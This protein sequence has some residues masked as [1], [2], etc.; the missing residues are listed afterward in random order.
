[1]IFVSG[2]LFIESEDNPWL[3]SAVTVEQAEQPAQDSMN[4]RECE[5]DLVMLYME[6]QM[7]KAERWRC[8]VEI[9][10]ELDE[11]D[12]EGLGKLY[13]LSRFWDSAVYTASYESA[14]EWIE[15]VKFTK[16][17]H[18]IVEIVKETKSPEKLADFHL[19]LFKIFAYHDLL[20]DWNK[21]DMTG[22]EA[23]LRRELEE[24]RILL[25]YRFGRL[26]Y[27]RF[28]DRY[29]GTRTEHLAADDVASLLSGTPKGVYQMDFF[30]TGPFGLLKGKEHRFLP[31][32]R[33]LPL[34][35]CSDTGCRSIHT[36][37]LLPPDIVL[38]NVAHQINDILRDKLGPCSEWDHALTN[39]YLKRLDSETK[40]LE[41]A[42]LPILIAD[43]II[44]D[45]RSELVE[46]VL[47]C[48][49]RSYINDVLDSA[50]GE[51]LKQESPKE[52]ARKLSAEEQLQL[53]LI[54]KDELIIRLID[55]STAKGLVKV[56]LGQIRVAKQEVSLSS[57]SSNCELSRLGLRSIKEHPITTLALLTYKAYSENDSI[58]EMN[59]RLHIPSGVGPMDG[60][61]HY[62]QQNGPEVVVT[63]LVLS[64][65]SVTEYV[66]KKLQLPIEN[67]ESSRLKP[68]E[69]IL[70][71]IGFDPPAYDDFR[72]RFLDH[73]QKFNAVVLSSPTPQSEDDRE[74]VRAVGVN[75][76]VY[77]EK[78]LDMLISYNIWLLASDHF[79]V[80]EFELE[81]MQ[82]RE[83][84]AE[85]LGKSLESNGTSL[86]WNIQG[87]NSLGVLLRYMSESI[88]WIESLETQNRDIWK[89]PDQD[90]PHFV[91]V[92]SL[93]FPFNHILLW[94][95]SDLNEFKKY[96]VGYRKIAKL[97]QQAELSY[98][99][100]GL[101]HMRDEVRFPK[102]EKMLACV[103]RLREAYDLAISERYLPVIFWLDK[104]EG[105]RF[106][107]VDYHLRDSANQLLVV[108]GPPMAL[109]LNKPKFSKP[110]VVAPGNLIGGPNVNLIFGLQERTEYDEYW[111]DYPRRRQIAVSRV[112]MSKD[113][114]S[115][116][117]SS[118]CTREESPLVDNHH[119]E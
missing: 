21:S 78:M 27:D 86:E 49:E 97:L 59:W 60:L 45:E 69:V 51:S 4:F 16:A 50:L 35:H 102:S 91:E 57:L 119:T 110:H 15:L 105:S 24:S 58:N 39:R 117:P 38:T 84:V 87:E 107:V 99:R 5:T 74:K 81:L 76:F 46:E 47:K 118:S 96:L 92:M 62:I 30:L 10:V 63:D 53:L 77:V 75:L 103:S 54:L 116:A 70:W 85:V 18:E 65:K 20:I 61:L 89:R 14:P 95:D 26:L 88:S 106:G 72:N 115:R 22:I 37:E 41:Y 3:L 93:R 71:K 42:D 114:G 79:L 2:Q 83:R 67:I 98:V 82:A 101:D 66:C 90:L 111:K 17:G 6:A 48:K 68:V 9:D 100:N 7:D 11:I 73:L 23:L 55:E 25:P 32:S 8:V 13:A 31:P 19:A 80:T 1:M 33:H 40:S 36:V 28:N 29:E 12:D 108:H 113:G 44:G 104:I 112:E 52:I 43:C 109:C 34:W 94:A 64:S 56:S